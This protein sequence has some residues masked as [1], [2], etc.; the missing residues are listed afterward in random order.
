MLPVV[1]LDGVAVIVQTARS[2][3]AAVRMTNNFNYLLILFIHL[4]VNGYCTIP[5]EC[6]CNSNWGGYNC[7]IGES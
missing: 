6:I 3:Q 7:S 2:V 5:N 4:L 1:S